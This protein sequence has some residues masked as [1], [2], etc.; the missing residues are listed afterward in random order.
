MGMFSSNASL[1]WNRQPQTCVLDP[2]LAFSPYGLPLVKHLREY[3][4][5]WVVRELWHILDNPRYY[6]QQ[7]ESMPLGAALDPADWNRPTHRQQM[8]Q[9]F[10]DWQSIRMSVDPTN[11]KL[12]WIGDRPSES[13]LPSGTDP[14]LAARWESLA[15]SL[16]RQFDGRLPSSEILAP[17]LR[18]TAAL[19]AALSSAFILTY[20]PEGSESN[21]TPEICLTLDQW[22]IPCQAIAALD[23]IAALEREHLIRLIITAGNL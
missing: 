13:F 15:R 17:A 21:L 19:A 23:P 8:N 1:T 9:T 10:Q 18:D 22:G 20:Q 7:P 16:D 2:G 12:F 11:L 5:L 14:Q 3:L 6:L 4:E